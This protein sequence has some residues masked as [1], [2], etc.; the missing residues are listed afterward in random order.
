MKKV[1]TIADF[2]LSVWISLPWGRAFLCDLH[3][4]RRYSIARIRHCASY[5]SVFRD[6][7]FAYEERRRTKARVERESDEFPLDVKRE[8]MRELFAGQGSV[9][10]LGTG[11]VL[12]EKGAGK[13]LQDISHAIRVLLKVFG[14]KK[15]RRESA[16]FANMLDVRFAKAGAQVTAAVS[17]FRALDY[18][19]DLVMIAVDGF[20]K[21]DFV[22][23]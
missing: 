9:F 22:V 23:L 17:A 20:V 18:R 7:F 2:S 15:F 19:K 5:F 13:F 8:G 14:E 4:A 6:N 1:R 3:V 11:I 16:G 10:V 21:T 12:R